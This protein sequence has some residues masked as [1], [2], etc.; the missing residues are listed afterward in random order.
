ML[1]FGSDIINFIISE[2]G[3]HGTSIG[4]KVELTIGLGIVLIAAA[5]AIEALVV[6]G[7]AV[8]LAELTFGAGLLPL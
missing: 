7:S 3:D 8:A 1:G 4:A 2:I 6:T 5:P